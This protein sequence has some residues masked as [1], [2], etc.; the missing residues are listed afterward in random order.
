MVISLYKSNPRPKG[1]YEDLP[2][3][4]REK[5][6]FT[7]AFCQLAVTLQQHS[8][9]HASLRYYTEGFETDRA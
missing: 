6:V 5:A 8:R 7:Q 3:S 9:P 4:F 2:R 1:K